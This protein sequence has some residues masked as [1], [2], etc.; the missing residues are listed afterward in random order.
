MRLGRARWGARGTV[1]RRGYAHRHGRTPDHGYR[2]VNGD[3]ASV[4]D[5][6]GFEGIDRRTRVRTLRPAFC[7]PRA[8]R[9]SVAPERRPPIA[10]GRLDC[11]DVSARGARSSS[12]PGA[13]VGHE[14]RARMVVASFTR[15]A[16]GL[17][18]SRWLADTPANRSK[19]NQNPRSLHYPVL[20]RNSFRTQDYR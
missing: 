19:R 16:R 2:H 10:G 1:P 6:L 4:I 14:R 8:T 20:H 5:E 7:G 13:W 3:G 9:T 18:R 15:Y 11:S 12:T 17:N